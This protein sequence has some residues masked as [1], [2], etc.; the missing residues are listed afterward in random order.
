MPPNPTVKRREA[1][2]VESIAIY[3]C[4]T[5]LHYLKHAHLCTVI[6]QT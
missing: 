4:S 3:G 2:S 1:D 5:L 6:T